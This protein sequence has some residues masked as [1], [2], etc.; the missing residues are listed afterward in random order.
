MRTPSSSLNL[1]SRR[2]IL[3]AGGMLCLLPSL[4]QAAWSPQSHVTL[5][6]ITDL[7]Y[8]EADPRGTRFY[9]ESLG[10][11]REA[12][13]SFKQA[14][15][16]AVIELGDLI[17]SADSQSAVDELR[18]LEK[19]MTE[20]RTVEAPRGFTIGNH[21]LTKVARPDFLRAVGQ[22]RGHHTMQLGAWTVIILDA[23]HKSDG[24][25]YSA[26]NFSWDDTDIPAKQRDWLA[27]ELKVASDHVLVC[28]HQ[29]VDWTSPNRP[30]TGV[31]S[32]PAIREI[33][34]QSKKVR[35]VLQGHTH[36][37][38]YSYLKDIHYVTLRAAVEGSGEA[39][40]G[41]SLLSLYED[42]TALLRGHREQLSRKLS[43]QD[44][45]AWPASR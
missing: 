34:E 9:R 19:V 21:C 28:V 35:V 14:K 44:E 6:L 10:K 33:L 31:A 26:G 39:N 41:Y 3:A 36:Q 37:N 5:G 27:H 7:H 42:G 45:I 22:P 2:E 43:S 23:C 38:D 20:L 12:V 11:L 24:T 17:D 1:V 18:F 8:G 25:P 4:S 16:D 13:Q 30:T 40:N 29:R 15:V 32:A